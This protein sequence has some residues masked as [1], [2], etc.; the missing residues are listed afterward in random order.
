MV[1]EAGLQAGRPGAAGPILAFR[2]VSLTYPAR[3][4]RPTAA[5]EDITLE[6]AAG[7]FLVLVGPSGCGKS[8]FLKLA[9]GLVRPT[10]GTVCRSPE[11]ERAAPGMV[12]QSPVLMDWRTVLG[13]VLFPLEVRARPSREAREKARALLS[14]AGLGGFEEKYP[15]ELSGGMRQRVAICRALVHDPPLL[16]MDEPFASL[17]ALTRDEM[18]L[19]LLRIWQ[20]TGKTVVFVTHSIPEAVLL[21]D[22]VV[23]LTPRPG[24]L[25]RVVSVTLPRPRDL[26]MSE[27]ASFQ[28]YVREIREEIYRGR[29]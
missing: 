14:M 22:R 27:G 11:L 4:G 23:V 17:D 5:L 2:G 19:E 20:G 26:A 25:A 9:A 1:A 7:E 10:A 3:D 21:A 13:N 12:F 6:V 24:R 29:R 15:S 16:L 8:S 28:A 18:S